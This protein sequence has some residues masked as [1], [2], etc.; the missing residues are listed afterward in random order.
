MILTKSAASRFPQSW[1]RKPFK[2]CPGPAEERLGDP[3]NL[4]GFFKSRFA[5]IR[6]AVLFAAAGV[7]LLA[8]GVALTLRLTERENVAFVQQ[9]IGD[10]TSL[11][12]AQVGLELERTQNLL[13]QLGQ[14]K[15][16]PM[17]TQ[18]ETELRGMADIRTSPVNDTLAS[19]AA[20]VAA[21]NTIGTVETEPEISEISLWRRTDP[22]GQAARVFVA[23]NSRFGDAFPQRMA[24]IQELEGSNRARIE[25]AFRGHAV[26]VADPFSGLDKSLALVAVPLGH[27]D[28][29][30]VIAAHVSMEKLQRLF[31][32][33]GLV[34][35]VLVDR[36]GAAVAHYDA[37]RLGKSE[38][39][40][41]R[42]LAP[43]FE[44]LTPA[45]SIESGLQALSDQQ[46]KLF[47]G[48]F[49]KISADGLV[50]LASVP[51][52]QTSSSLVSV[53]QQLS[54][55]LLL[56]FLVLG[57]VRYYQLNRRKLALPSPASVPK[58]ASP[59]AQPGASA[60]KPSR[61]IAV[62]ALHGSLR[63]FTQLL[64][65]GGPEEVT[66]AINDY[67]TAVAFR[68]TSYG[69][70]FERYPG[71][72]FGA[73]WELGET[74]ESAQEALNQA[75][76]CAVSLRFDLAHLNESRKLDG[77]KQ[78]RHGMGLHV[79]QALAARIGPV[80]DIRYGVMGE[81]LACARALDRLGLAEGKELI[82][83]QE[84]LKAAH[85]TFSG[86][87]LGEAR[88]TE[89][90]GLTPYYGI[91]SYREDASATTGTLEAATLSG[92]VESSE[93]LTG[94]ETRGKIM[95][96]GGEA[97]RWLVNNGSQIEGPFTT[98]ELS[99]RLFTQEIDFD[100]ECWNEETGRSAK[101]ENA[102]IFSGSQDADACYW[103]YDGQMIHGPVSEGFVTTAFGHGAFGQNAFVCERSTVAGWRPLAAL[104]GELIDRKPDTDSVPKAS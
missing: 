20:I 15:I 51:A 99:A 11:L 53:T 17:L 47:F 79:G 95:R 68:V 88:L 33:D 5:S 85:G 50:V 52:E 10:T 64:E 97:Q 60:V 104:V 84:V 56:I 16:K 42:P 36:D 57:S 41:G 7:G 6:S 78:L 87:Q 13:L 37:K 29:S 82:V 67:L 39:E 71:A 72:S 2:W 96:P 25:A 32:V 12:A 9:S 93:R 34:Q 4:S 103:V 40:A 54:V 74:D 77:K 94:G 45:A 101:I 66:E 61:K 69:A 46:G 91:L 80:A 27:G 86:K 92:A 48:G 19:T 26:V 44:H 58:T 14:E 8:L 49:R 83:S 73:A 30:E 23:V 31:L 89:D 22:H 63:G 102:G 43:L 62:V 35:A 1:R 28:V 55:T 59:A 75:L 90:T 24:R 81:A 3:L 70:V 18:Q 100:C 98:Q 76:H 38:S 65:A 21:T